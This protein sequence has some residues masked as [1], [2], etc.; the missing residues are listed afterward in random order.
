MGI[1]PKG[2]DF[3]QWWCLLAQR[4]KGSTTYQPSM[5]TRLPGPLLRMVPKHPYGSWHRARNNFLV[6]SEINSN[7]PLKY[8]NIT[9]PKQTYHKE[10]NFQENLGQIILP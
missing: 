7:F 6:N 1:A 3:L 5:P 9:M 10:I 8:R 2:L 4:L